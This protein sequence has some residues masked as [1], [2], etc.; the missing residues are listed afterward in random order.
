MQRK[1][2]THKPSF[3]K[4]TNLGAR[5]LGA[6]TLACSDDFF[7]PMH[8]L[9]KE[10]RGVFIE[11]KYTE[12]GKWMDG[13][14]SRRKRIP[15][16]DWC[17]IRLSVPGIIHGLD[18]DT[19]HF[20]GNHP[21]FASVEGCYY[22]GDVSVETLMSAQTNWIPLTGKERLEAGSHNFVRISQKQPFT[23]LKLNIFPDGGI[24][25]FK[26]YGDVYKN[27]SLLAP[28]TQIDLVAARNGGRALLCNDMFFSHM[29]NL[30]M[31]GR[32]KNMGDGW[33]T[34]RN[35]K[36]DNVDWVVIKLAHPGTVQKVLIDTAHFKG[37]FPDSC[38][39][40]G[41]LLDEEATVE[42][43]A[44][45]WQNLLPRQK[46]KAD[47]EHIFESEIKN[48]GPFSHIKLNI[49][50]DGGISRLRVLGTINF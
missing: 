41:C 30:L 14:E 9:L 26:V 44:S 34:K 4:L 21:P 45:Y 25:R 24:A 38:S 15:G 47:T 36:P 19:N 37:N 43:N 8:N 29:Q 7:A 50:P 28:E 16:N 22:E 42:E 11:D 12:N 46:L 10:G 35:R 1:T 32:G 13:W 33:E 40:Q 27:W 48:H 3:T 23:H 18:I 49:F 2:N 31:P 39:I 17:L 6:E 5:K 20:L